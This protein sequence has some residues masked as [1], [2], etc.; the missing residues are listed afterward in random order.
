MHK[1]TLAFI[2]IFIIP[3]HGWELSFLIKRDE[4]TALVYR[5]HELEPE[6][7]EELYQ[8]YYPRI[9]DHEA[10]CSWVDKMIDG[11][12][13]VLLTTKESRVKDLSNK[14]RENISIHEFEDTGEGT[15][16]AREIF[17]TSIIGV[18]EDAILENKEQKLLPPPPKSLL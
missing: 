2:F 12:L 9:N 13:E 15:H 7:K 6:L 5:I 10:T 14:L 4:K 11:P 16:I 18:I 17:I 3:L 1:K 8:L